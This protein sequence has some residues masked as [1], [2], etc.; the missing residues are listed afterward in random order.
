M[1]NY[2]ELVDAAII[3]GD[4]ID[5]FNGRWARL[6]VEK[7]R[8]GIRDKVMGD[9]I[10]ACFRSR[11]EKIKSGKVIPFRR[12]RF[13]G[14]PVLLGHDLA[15]PWNFDGRIHLPKAF[16]NAHWLGFAQTGY[17]KS[18]W[19]VSLSLELAATG[20]TTWQI[21]FYKD[22][23][24]GQLMRFRSAGLDLVVVGLDELRLNPLQ[25]GLNEPR[26][27]LAAVL[28]RLERCLYDLPPR[29]SLLLRAACHQV[30][31]EF[32][33]FTGQRERWPNLFR[34]YEKIR[35]TQGQNVA[36]KDA[37]LD[38][39]G[40]FLERVTP[41]CGAWL[42]AWNPTDLAKLPMLFLFRKGAEDIKHFTIDSLLDHV[43]QHQIERGVVNR[44]VE[45]CIFVDDAQT[46]VNHNGNATMSG[47]D[48][49][50]GKIRGGGIS[51]VFFPQTIRGVSPHLLPNIGGWFMGGTV[52]HETRMT[53]ARNVGMNEAQLDWGRLH[54][55]PG[56]FIGFFAVGDWH[57]P[58]VFQTPNINLAHQVTEADR[59]DSQQPLASLPLIPDVEFQRWER[60]PVVELQPD[61]TASTLSPPETRLQQAV[62]ANPGKPAG[63]YTRQ[64]GMN[65]KVAKAARER[66]VQLGLLREHRVQLNR[67]GKA[68]IVLEPRTNHPN[69]NPGQ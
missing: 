49:K 8:R 69:S 10:L 52:E 39:L 27:H 53:F 25:A 12:G 56:Q 28:A 4:Q 3:E 62:V 13:P 24:L 66:L 35:T 60:N 5:A 7:W 17:G 61:L 14:G 42:R 18:V 50:I 48:E 20:V 16:F 21:S 33:I 9:T 63:C 23:L 22:D 47:L 29:A 37:L 38:R 6:C 15:V 30:Y 55:R 43:F 51:V 11:Q 67:R 54:P 1:K 44:G 45:L 34:V 57:E 46:L 2:F 65:G 59:R 41:R 68:S 32:A 58:F 31:Q 26:G 19:E 64:L 40:S 36:A